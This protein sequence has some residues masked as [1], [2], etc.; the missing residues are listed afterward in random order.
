MLADH[1]GSARNQKDA[2]VRRVVFPVVAAAALAMLLPQSPATAAEP[3]TPP[4]ATG[5]VTPV[6][7]GIY[8]SASGTYRIAENDVPAGLMGRSHAVTAQTG[9][10]AQAQDAPTNRADLGVFGPSWEA[11]FVGGQLNRKLTP[12]SGQISITDLDTAETARYDLTDSLA[13]P[14]GGSVNIYKA[15]DGS[16]VAENIAWDDLTGELKTTVTETLNIDL[17]A[18]SAGPGDDAP[19]DSLGNPIPGAD[20]KPSYTWKKVSGAGDPWRVTAVGSKAF[21]PTTISYDASGRVSTVKEPQ[22]GDSPAQSLKVDYATATTATA[23]TTGDVNGQVKDITLTVGADVTTLA[24][25]SYDASR[26]LRKVDNPAAGT[27]LNAYTYDSSNRVSS[28]TTEEGAKWDLTFAGDAA[29]PSATETTGTVPAPNS[30]MEGA[31]SI[32]EPDGVTPAASDFTGSEITTPQAYPSYCNT[33]ASWMWYWYRGCATKVA[34]YGWHNPY[35]RQT[36]TGAWVVGIY[37]D[38]CTWSLDKPRGWDFRPACDSHDYG[39]GTIG[40]SYKGY[41][42]YLDRYKGLQ[43]DVTFYRQLYYYT[44]PAYSWKSACRSTAY[45]YYTAV[46]YNGYPK[47]GAD[48]T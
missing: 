7:P 31:P 10:V 46:L 8:T 40:N 13:G 3:P 32:T 17:T 1:F 37:H 45:A 18:A 23:T 4:L 15:S 11:E 42:Y 6:G 48:A 36:P 21:K 35:W 25:Y 19:Q 16:V 28:V 38:H 12:G 34:H 43:V 30:T 2:N 33:A 22:R 27:D 41:R 39:Y 20:L 14:N 24:R 47:K 29:E 26:L 44:C 9:G 5:V